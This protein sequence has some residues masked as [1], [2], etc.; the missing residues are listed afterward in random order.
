MLHG[1]DFSKLVFFVN[2]SFYDTQTPV[3]LTSLNTRDL[4]SRCAAH[5]QSNW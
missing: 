3:I 5:T 1:F 4:Y 2:T